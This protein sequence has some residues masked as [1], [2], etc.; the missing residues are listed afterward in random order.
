MTWEQ[1]LKSDYWSEAKKDNFKDETVHNIT[2]ALGWF[3]RTVLA[4]LKAMLIA[5]IDAIKLFLHF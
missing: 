5:L 3:L 2:V 4:G 1:K